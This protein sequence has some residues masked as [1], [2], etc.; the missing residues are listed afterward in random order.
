M[1]ENVVAYMTGGKEIELDKETVKNYLVRGEGQIT[2]QEALM[3]MELCKYQ[4]L[5]PFLNDAYLIKYD[6]KR[7]AS[8]VVGK[9]AY[10]KRAMAQED[11]KGFEAGIIVQ[12]GD[13]IIELEGSFKAPKDILLGGWAKVFRGGAKEVTA[14][15]SM[16]EYSTDRSLWKSKPATM[17]R[18]V[19]LVQAI[20][21]SYPDEFAGMYSEEEIPS[22]QEEVI[23]EADYEVVDVDL[24]EEEKNLT[25]TASEQ[26]LPGMEDEDKK[27]EALAQLYRLVDEEGIDVAEVTGLIQGQYGRDKS[28]DLTIKEIEDLMDFLRY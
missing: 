11:F 2:D 20:R 13:E 17:I 12:R 28:S 3:F 25:T 7:P 26:T 18:K 24:E 27:R 10:T 23:E 14:K 21:E 15:V 19:A 4:G 1:A 16:A 6:N 5:N 22:A 8:I 9:E